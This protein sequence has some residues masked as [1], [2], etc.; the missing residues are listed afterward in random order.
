MAPS[1]LSTHNSLR[2]HYV[3]LPITY[4]E[5]LKFPLRHTKEKPIKLLTALEKY[6]LFY[7]SCHIQ[8]SPAETCDNSYT[9]DL[10][11]EMGQHGMEW[12]ATEEP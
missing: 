9:V 3:I 12:K 2:Y 1:L 11:S 10:P 5:N 4:W 7:L 8:S 6:L